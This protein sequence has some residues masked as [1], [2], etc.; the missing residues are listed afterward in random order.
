[1]NRTIIYLIIALT[2]VSCSSCGVPESARINFEQT[3]IDKYDNNDYEEALIDFD[4]HLAIYPLDTSA[5]INRAR[6]KAMLGDFQGSLNDNS[7]AL[8][9]DPYE[10]IAL[11]NRALDKEELNDNQGAIEDYTKIIALGPEDLSEI[12]RKRGSIKHQLHDHT[13]A[14]E[15]FKMAIELDPNN[16]DAYVN[17]A[18]V[19]MDYDLLSSIADLNKALEIDKEK[20]SAYFVRGLVNIKLNKKQAGCSD[21]QKAISLN[22]DLAEGYYEQH[23]VLPQNTYLVGEVIDFGSYTIQVTTFE[24]KAY[25]N[26]EFQPKSGNKLVAVEFL[27]TNYG[28]STIEYNALEFSL[29][30]ENSYEYEIVI[31][32]FKEPY[33]SS[34]NVQPGR[35]ARGWITF[36]VP[37]GSQKFEVKYTPGLFTGTTDYFIRLY[38]DI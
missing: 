2:I 21:L 3:G 13:G 28:K 37:K 27:M 32:G 5:Y 20:A 8:E 19:N 9:I 33:F 1:M 36:E 10:K 30:D 6:A 18:M 17:R 7:K 35:K 34:G 15:D 12:Y 29:M 26:F 4:K 16:T 25:Y 14:I 22:Y 38:D 24:E 31:F 23:C 11:V